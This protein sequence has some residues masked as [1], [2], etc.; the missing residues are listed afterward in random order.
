MVFAGFMLGDEAMAS[1]TKGFPKCEFGEDNQTRYGE[2]WTGAK[3]V[4][5]G[6]SG[7]SSATG[8]P[9]RPQWG[10]YEHMHP[11]LWDQPG[12]RNVQSEAYRRC[13]T[14]C[15]W[16]GEAL[17]MRILKLEKQWNHDAFFDY[18]DRWMTEDDKPFAAEIFKK[19]GDKNLV[20]PEKAWCHEGYTGDE[21]VKPAWEQYRTMAGMPA[22]DGWKTAKANP[23]G[24]E[25]PKVE[26]A[27]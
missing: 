14:S 27:K 21:W 24:E 22:T 19:T 12:Q 4:F 23:D 5:A 7:I 11:S 8:K 10:P 15:C 25:L 6:H 18:V 13:N 17:A 2:G 26:E 16:V 20:N 9:P 1:P 3:V